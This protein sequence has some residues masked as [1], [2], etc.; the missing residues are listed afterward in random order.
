MPAITAD[1]ALKAGVTP[2]EITLANA[3]AGDGLT[4]SFATMLATACDTPIAPMRASDAAPAA[5]AP[6]APAILESM[7]MTLTVGQDIAPGIAMPPEIAA[8]QVIIPA[9]PDQPAPTKMPLQ[10][11]APSD[12][13]PPVAL[14]E[15][16]MMTGSLPQAGVPD[17]SALHAVAGPA[18]GKPTTKAGAASTKPDAPEAQP[19]DNP[20]PLLAPAFLAP[21]PLVTA[22]PPPP[23]EAPSGAPL[24]SAIGATGSAPAAPRPEPSRAA[25]VKPRDT[26]D[27]DPLAVPTPSPT[28]P[29]MPADPAIQPAPQTP[30]AAPVPAAAALH[31]SIHMTPAHPGAPPSQGVANQLGSAF[32]V[33]ARDGEGERHLTMTLQPPDLGLLRI[34]IEQANDSPSKVVI[35]ATNPSTLL[36]LLR[37]QTALNQALDSAGIGGDGRAVTFHLAA[38]EALP[39][40]AVPPGD[41]AD[42]PRSGMFQFSSQTEFGP[43][44][45]ER[46]QPRGQQTPWPGSND[47]SPTDAATL[48]VSH[49][50]QSGIDITA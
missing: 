49:P 39:S 33:L 6:P 38:N 8:Y 44:G 5:P 11:S 45:R 31:A 41:S 10:A 47:I 22:S 21:P 48:R 50:A 40:P 25:E 28:R 16:D 42:L 30:Y 13:A 14:P 15:P 23:P 20:A 43:D 46:S 37:D 12:L 9:T 19:T 34:S 17:S 3:S 29:D 32:V 7:F 26:V 27:Q 4:S 24:G 18:P 2:R 36:T 35:T 1:P